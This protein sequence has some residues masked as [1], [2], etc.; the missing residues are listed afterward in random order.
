MIGINAKFAKAYPQ[1]L[2]VRSPNKQ[3]NKKTMTPHIKL[4]PCGCATLPRYCQ[5]LAD[6]AIDFL[7]PTSFLMG[8]AHTQLAKTVCALQNTGCTYETLAQV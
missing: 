8:A 7:R 3:A 4:I 5:A 1:F 6:T 2:I